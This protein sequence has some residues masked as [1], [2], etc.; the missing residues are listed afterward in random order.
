ME[1]I[2]IPRAGY[3]YE[4]FPFF[5]TFFEKL[6]FR[7]IL[8]PMTDRDILTEGL[9]A[10]D[11]GM[12][13]PAKV[14][15]GHCLWLDRQGVDFVFVPRWVSAHR[16]VAHKKEDEYFCPYFIGFSDILKNSGFKT[17]IINIDLKLSEK[18][19]DIEAWRKELLESLGKFTSHESLKY[20]VKDARVAQEKFE[21]RLSGG[22]DIKQ[23][24]ADERVEFS[25]KSNSKKVLVIGRSYLLGDG[26]I[27]LNLLEKIRGYGYQPVLVENVGRE[28][29]DRE[30]QKYGKDALSHWSQVNDA[31][32]AVSYFQDKD[33]TGII[34]L[35]AFPCG[36]DFLIYD[37]F[38]KRVNKNVPLVKIVI[39]E[40]SGEAGLVTRLEAFFDMIK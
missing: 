17:P 5:K 40:N 33:L 35:E 4:Y 11:S 7:V 12:C 26:F 30:F 25:E 18:H 6:G 22:A 16:L 3:Y 27:N 8:S 20:A 10:A 13:L 9:K 19:F 32:A 21:N 1:T 23:A 34:H 31:L 39:D 37:L 28:N 36:P 15:F 14:F 24:L 38:M 2:G 29:L